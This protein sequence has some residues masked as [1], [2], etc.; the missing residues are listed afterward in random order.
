MALFTNGGNL[1][2]GVFSENWLPEWLFLVLFVVDW[3]LGFP[4]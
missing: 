3:L 4:V 2:K 1:V